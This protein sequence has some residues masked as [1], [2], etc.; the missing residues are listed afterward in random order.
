M[1]PYGAFGESDLEM[2]LR[3]AQD[4][5][6]RWRGELQEKIEAW[7]SEQGYAPLKEK[8]ALALIDELRSRG[9]KSFDG[10][11]IKVTF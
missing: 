4:N 11:G 8:A 2:L 9:V 10:L 1:K 3:G 5:I 6:S 7:V